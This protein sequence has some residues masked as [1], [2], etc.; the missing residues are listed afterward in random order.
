MEEKGC[1]LRYKLPLWGEGTSPHTCSFAHGV[2]FGVEPNVIVEGLC[3][4]WLWC[5]CNVLV[6]RSRTCA[7]WKLE[8]SP[9]TLVLCTWE[10]C[11]KHYSCKQF[12]P[13][14]RG[15]VSSRSTYKQGPGL[16]DRTPFV[17]PRKKGTSKS[18]GP[19]LS[20]T[21]DK[22]ILVGKNNLGLSDMETWSSVGPKSRGDMIEQRGALKKS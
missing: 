9:P 7:W 13:T 3:A 4:V 2:W 15:K 12:P 19:S 20:A 18:C 11:Q 5:W 1:K 21:M 17:Q 22:I 10:S 14:R 8:R 16:D 6:G